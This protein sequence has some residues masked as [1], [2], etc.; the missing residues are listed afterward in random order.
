MDGVSPPSCGLQAAA[1]GLGSPHSRATPLQASG[2]GREA[3]LWFVSLG[4][5]LFQTLEL[6]GK[7]H[8]FRHPNF[9]TFTVISAKTRVITCVVF[10]STEEA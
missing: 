6:G 5:L 8:Q 1:S 2:K 7:S 10:Y 9:D 4:V 3:A